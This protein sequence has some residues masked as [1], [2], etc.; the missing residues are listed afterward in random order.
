MVSMKSQKYSAWGIVTKNKD[1]AEVNSAHTL[2]IMDGSTKDG[3]NEERQNV[4][5]GVINNILWVGITTKSK[6]IARVKTTHTLVK[7]NDLYEVT[8]TLW[9]GE[10]NEEYGCGTG[11]GTGT[12]TTVPNFL[13]RPDTSFDIQ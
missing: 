3:L 13:G 1:V 7:Q 9:V 8:N 4:F 10:R 5:N 12:G 2:A 6:D 11:T